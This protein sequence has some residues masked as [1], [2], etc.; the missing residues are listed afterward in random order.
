M[1]ENKSDLA[2]LNENILGTENKITT[3]IDK[4]MVHSNEKLDDSLLMITK[5]KAEKRVHTEACERERNEQKIQ[6]LGLQSEIK[7][8]RE[9][10][11]K[12]EENMQLAHAIK[13]LTEDKILTLK[14]HEE[15]TKVGFMSTTNDQMLIFGIYFIHS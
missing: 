6:I 2:E 4:K 14:Q 1:D 10:V 5:L 9:M 8:S 13:A 7:S 15:I 3:L 11:Q 12:A